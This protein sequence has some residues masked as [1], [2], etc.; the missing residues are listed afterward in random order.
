AA[1]T[2]AADI[3]DV[4][5]LVSLVNQWGLYGT[6]LR[7]KLEDHCTRQITLNTHCEM[8][9]IETNRVGGSDT[10]TD[11]FGIP[12]PTINF[13]VDDPTGYTRKAFDTMVAFHKWVFATLGATAVHLGSDPS[14]G[15]LNF[16]GAGHLMG[17]TLMGTDPAKSVVDRD[18]RSHDHQN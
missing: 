15:P 14:D 18:C 4:G 6:E 9:P 3:D 8:L 7:N 5:T 11:R 16:L 13:T 10:L 17:T 1:T 2:A 12:R